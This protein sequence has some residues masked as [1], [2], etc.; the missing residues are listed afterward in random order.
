MK[1]S[2]DYIGK[3]KYCAKILLLTLLFTWLINIT[4]LCYSIATYFTDLSIATR[5]VI[6]IPVQ[7]IR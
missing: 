2:S 3:Y 5:H 7:I 6:R 4:S 1:P